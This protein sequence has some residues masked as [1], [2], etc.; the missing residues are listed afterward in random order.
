MYSSGMRPLR[1][2]M[3]DDEE[4]DT[5]RVAAEL[6]SGGYEPEFR[7]VLSAGELREALATRW[8]LVVSD[9]A[10]FGAMDVPQALRRA[11]VDLPV[12]VVS[13][14]DDEDERGAALKAGADDF[15]LLENLSRLSAAVERG[16]RDA[17]ERRARREAEAKARSAEAQLQSLIEEIPAL[18]FVSWADDQGSPAYVS[19]QLRA[20]TGFTPAEWLADPGSW[21]NRLHP[22]DK[23]RTL[24]EYREGCRS[25]QP[26]VSEYRILDSEGRVVWWRS[27]ARVMQGA[28]GGPRFVRGF[29]VDVSERKR[30]EETIRLMAFRDPVTGLANRVLL[31]K[32]LDQALA[33]EKSGEEPMALLLV[34]L[35]RL[36][37]I[38]TMFGQDNADLLAREIARR[39]ADVVGEQEQV[40]RLRGDEFAL[41][42]PGAGASLAQQVAAKVL[43]ALERPVML[44]KLPIEVGASAGIAISPENGDTA[45][46]LLR[47]ADLALQAARRS[48]NRCALYSDACE[49][50]D[51][52]QLALL[53]E[54]RQAL[55]SHQLLLHYQPKVDLKTRRLVGAEALVRWRHPRRGLVPP[56]QFIALAEQGGLIKPLTRFVLGEALNQCGIWARDQPLPVAVNLSARDLHDPDLVEHISAELESKGVAAGQLGLELTEST[57]MVDP[58]RAADTLRRIDDSGVRIAIDDFGTGYSS[59]AYLRKLPFSELK[60][61]KSFVMR[62]AKEEGD[63]AIVRSTSDL[64]HNLGMSVVAEGVEDERTLDV[65]SSFGCD[66]AQGYFLGRPMPAADLAVW[67]RQSPFA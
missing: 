40:A 32:R 56:D 11:G 23:E 57:L 34:A 25:R 13:E 29:I 4:E 36:R 58:A 5:L 1:I 27:E 16:L 2:L 7:R 20:M 30:A 17:A 38:T 3:L 39:L 42:L 43:R 21:A 49:Q 62:L 14:S 22:D 12:I 59:L 18:T 6:R 24:A 37:E 31:R 52:K 8:D 15:V 55:E 26:F 61:D 28:A 46:L 64:G 53:G 66:A 9:L 67:R 10:R 63:A 65:L 45:E 60:I 33:Q 44:E 41:L 51:P 50:H 19:P 35:G 47:R 54:L 48:E